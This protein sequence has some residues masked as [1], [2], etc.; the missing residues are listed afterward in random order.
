MRSIRQWFVCG[1]TIVALAGSGWTEPPPA[2]SQPESGSKPA[3]PA[4]V[5]L[6][7][8]AGG[9]NV[10][11][12]R[13][14]PFNAEISADFIRK[15]METSAK[16]EAA[17]RQITERQTEL[18]ATNPEIKATR[19]RMIELQ[20]EINKILDADAELAEL[21]MSRD[22]LWSTMPAMP[23]GRDPMTLPPRLPG[24]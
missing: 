3:V 14:A 1:A 4:P 24:R 8:T 23:K 16:I 17:K 18:Y 6:G 9:T 22:L 12:G 7:R 15:V 19:E 20:K 21:K 2:E 10:A 5:L 13:P 11:A